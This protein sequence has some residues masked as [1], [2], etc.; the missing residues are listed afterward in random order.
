M[1]VGNQPNVSFNPATGHIIVGYENLS[2]T[3]P[4]ALYAAAQRVLRREELVPRTILSGTRTIPVPHG[5]TP[6]Q[7]FS[8]GGASWKIT[9]EKMSA[10]VSVS[11]E[12]G[13][14]SLT[15]T[16]SSSLNIG[17]SGGSKISM[18]YAIVTTYEPRS[19]KNSPHPSLITEKE[20]RDFAFLA[21][22]AAV[23]AIV[24]RAAVGGR[25]FAG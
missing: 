17:G 8:V 20:V 12:H 7:V 15:I 1:S 24:I 21:G 18:E 6:P 2:I 19:S 22:S 13:S 9:L 14:P 11:V 4:G 25:A 3:D 5:K 10:S 16:M 23:A